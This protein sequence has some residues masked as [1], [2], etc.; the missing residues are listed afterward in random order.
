MYLMIPMFTTGVVNWILLVFLLFYIIFDIGVKM[1][2]GCLVISKQLSSVIGD[3]AGGALLSGAIVLAMY[4][5]RSQ[6]FLFFADQTANGAVCSR[7]S[8]QSFKCAVYKNGELVTT[9]N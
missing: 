1:M 6:N 8:K 4:A 7:P 2:Q 3:F 5:G 9:D